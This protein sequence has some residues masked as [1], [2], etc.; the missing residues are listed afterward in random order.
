[1]KIRWEHELQLNSLIDIGAAPDGWLLIGRT[2]GATL[3]DER[4]HI[5]KLAPTG[6]VLWHTEYPFT[7]EVYWTRVITGTHDCYLAG[8]TSVIAN[9]REDSSYSWSIRHKHYLGKTAHRIARIAEDGSYSWTRHLD[10]FSP[11]CFGVVSSRGNIVLAGVHR[12]PVLVCLNAQGEELWRKAFPAYRGIPR[13]FLAV[14]DGF[15]LLGDNPHPHDEGGVSVMKTDENGNELWLHT[16]AGGWTSVGHKLVSVDEG[17]VLAGEIEHKIGWM[18]KIRHTGEAVPDW[19]YHY[20]DKDGNSG[21]IGA[22]EAHGG[23]LLAGKRGSACTRLRH[24]DATGAVVRQW[25]LRGWPVAL[26]SRGDG[27]LLVRELG[28]GKSRRVLLTSF[29]VATT[30]TSNRVTG[31]NICG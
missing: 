24:V 28:R 20:P 27:Y 29:E 7:G 2:E 26:Q 11:I 3:A 16:Y 14:E 18:Q 21:L 25:D 15:V 13:D 19:G 1:M 30:T 6:D 22:A 8:S 31:Q 12:S 23:T 5:L 4:H 10:G 17:V 9:S